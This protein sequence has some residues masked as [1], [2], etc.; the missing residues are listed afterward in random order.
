MSAAEDATAAGYLRGWHRSAEQTIALQAAAAPL[1]TTLGQLAASSQPAEQPLAPADPAALIGT[2]IGPYRLASIIASGGMGIVYRAYQHSPV[3]RQVALKMIRA[4]QLGDSAVRRFAAERQSLALMDHPDIAQVYQAGNTPSGQ[5]YYAMELCSG[6]P[7]DRYCTA[8]QLSLAERLPLVIRVARAVQQAHSRGVIHR[9][10]KPDNVLVADC[11]G[12]PS[13]KVIDFGIAKLTGAQWTTS[14]GPATRAGELVG[15]PAY[16][17]PEQAAEGEID[18]RTDV[19]AIG[20]LLFKLL[21][22]TTPLA[23]AAEDDSGVSSLAEIIQRLSQFEP[24]TPS[25]RFASLPAESRDRLGKQMGAASPKRLA[26][27]LRGDLDWIVLKALQPD[28]LRRY[29]TAS[30]LADDIQRFL[31]HRPVTAAAPSWRYRLG[32]FYQRRRP[33]VLAIASIAGTVLLAVLVSGVAWMRYSAERRAEVA[34]L[35]DEVDVLLDEANAFRARAVRGGPDADDDFSAAQTAA[36][37]S[38]SLLAG[39]DE[40]PELRQRL[41][42]VQQSLV[43]DS[44]AL[45]LARQ[46]DDARLGLF[47]FGQQ[48][49]SDRLGRQDAIRRVVEALQQFGITPDGTDP[50]SVHARLRGCPV[51]TLETVIQTLDFLI[52]EVPLGAG[53]YLHAQ[54]GRLSIARLVPGGAADQQGILRPGDRLLAINDLDLVEDAFDAATAYRQLQ[55]PPGEQILLRVVRDLG[56]PLNIQLT[57]RGDLAH[58][59]HDVLA[60]LDPDPWR[61]SLRRAVLDADLQALQRCAGHERLAEQ[62]PH[63]LIQLAGSLFLL[64]S[65]DDSIDI[66]R[67][68]QRRYPGNYWTNHYLGISLASAVQPPQPAAA[69]RYLTTAVGLRP[70]HPAARINLAEGLLAAGELSAALNQLQLAA[71]MLPEDKQLQRRIAWLGNELARQ[72]DDEPVR[73]SPA[74]HSRRSTKLPDGDAGTAAEIPNDTTSFAADHVEALEAEARQLAQHGERQRAV[75]LIRQGRARLGDIPQ[76]RRAL[77][78]VLLDVGDYTAARIALADAARRMPTDAATRFY[79][80][81]ALQYCGDSSAAIREYQSALQLRP[82]YA[83]VHPFLSPLLAADDR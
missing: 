41:R 6:E 3:R 37:K 32:K 49:A 55:R 2:T 69:L 57:C 20:A 40:F 79:F 74:A 83:A 9:D 65:P 51:P 72:A 75:A 34:R 42:A 66:L 15:T 52:G 58:W 63:S 81:V 35:A 29:A 44:R 11:E 76:L 46:L 4:G 30:D 59:A 61:G 12:G 80:G 33:L 38:A 31:E 13:V 50:S 14:A 10:L 77:G 16:M 47:A 22:G 25:V 60:L 73:Q 43:A 5:P 48:A 54:Q 71:E 64:Q 45:Q 7:I 18:A 8:K 17:S 26:A 28:R 53:V 39:R 21:T 82:D 67:L 19:F 62:S 78:A 23:A 24:V 56:L 70:D 68:A 1:A 27:A 36:A